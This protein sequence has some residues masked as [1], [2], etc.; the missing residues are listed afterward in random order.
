MALKALNEGNFDAEALKS[1]KPAFVDF[2]AQWCG[3]CRL[4][5]PVVEEVAAEFGDRVDFFKVNVDEA[6][7]L[8]A[9]YG[10]TGIPTSIV[11]RNGKVVADHSG[12]MSK[13]ALVEFINESLQRS[14]DANKKA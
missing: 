7:S 5:L 12:S 1:G 4:Y 11:F 13:K 9:R 2:W 6:P 10:I 8:P 14:A 3:P